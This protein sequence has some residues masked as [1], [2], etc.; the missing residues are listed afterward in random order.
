M[1]SAERHMPRK[2]ERKNT[3][4]V[5]TFASSKSD[6]ETVG[7]LRTEKES[8]IVVVKQSYPNGAAKDRIFEKNRNYGE[9]RGTGGFVEGSCYVSLDSFVYKDVVVEDRAQ[10]ISSHI[11]G[12]VVIGGNEI[13]EDSVVDASTGTIQA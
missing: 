11:S 5:M 3:V 7:I 4:I 2:E 9:E 13:I 1:V 8:D 12:K 10:V 6:P